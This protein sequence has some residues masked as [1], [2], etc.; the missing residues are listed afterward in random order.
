[1]HSSSQAALSAVVSQA[2]AA[3]NPYDVATPALEGDPRRAAARRAVESAI[4]SAAASG[5]SLDRDKVASAALEELVGLGA[6]GA[7]VA[8][9]AVRGAV[10]QGIDGVLVDRGQGLAPHDGCFSSVEALTVIV[11]RM[12][13]MAGGYFDRNKPIHE[14][15]LPNGV[16]FHAVL[17]PVAVGGPVVELRRLQRGAVTGEQLV[18]RGVLS[19]DILDLLRRAVRV[20]KGVAV[21]GARDAGVSQLVSA[22]ANLGAPD[23]RILAIE[24]VPDLELAS[25]EAVRLTAAAGATFESVIEQGGRMHA[26]RVVIDG[27]RGG[28]ALAALV[29]A[30]SRTGA[31]LGVHSQGGPDALAHLVAL[32]AIG[33]GARDALPALVGSAIGIVVRMA[34]AGDGRPR[35]ESVGEV[36]VSESGA[37]LVELFGSNFAA[38]GQSAGF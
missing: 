14:G 20:R 12:V 29:T 11:G 25:P 2:A 34:R 16:H 37:T 21:V 36:R 24:V 4:E 18:A 35:V 10:V 32:A 28:E 8:D 30:A 6:I 13:A 9:T 5:M 23:E 3:F 31:V 7:I 15:T 33:G 19:S 27:V 22:V 26:D 17:P 38:T 1:M